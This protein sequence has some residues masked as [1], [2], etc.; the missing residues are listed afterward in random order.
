MSK[1]YNE[2]KKIFGPNPKTGKPMTRE[3]FENAQKEAH[4]RKIE[5]YLQKS[6]RRPKNEFP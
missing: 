6:N 4:A 2:A 1:Y 5:A 3:E